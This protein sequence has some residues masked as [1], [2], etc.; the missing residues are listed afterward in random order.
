[1]EDGTDNMA[2]FDSLLT[3]FFGCVPTWGDD[4][5]QESIADLHEAAML[6]L[7]GLAASP[8]KKACYWQDYVLS[9]VQMQAVWESVE[10]G[11]TALLAK[12]E[13]SLP[14]PLLVQVTS[15]HIHTHTHTHACAHTHTRTHT[16]ACTHT[17]TH[18]H[19]VQCVVGLEVPLTNHTIPTPTDVYSVVPWCC[20]RGGAFG[21]LWIASLV[22]YLH[23]GL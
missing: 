13:A 15:L 19:T 9:E 7:K 22:C 8:E 21:T 5:L 2:D 1:M 3:R 4:K 20:K 6:R 12:V 14:K 18:T 11:V 10:K 23:T 16:H 17:C